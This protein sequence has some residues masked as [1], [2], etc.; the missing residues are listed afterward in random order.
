MVPQSGQ[1]SGI[2]LPYEQAA[3]RGEEMPKGLDYPD[4]ILFIMLRDLY[5]RF[6]NGKIEKESARKEKMQYL[7]EYRGYK[8]NWEMGQHWAQVLIK[9]DLARSEYKKNP[10]IENADRLVAVL[11]G[12]D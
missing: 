7:E 3:I 6:R 2:V 9:T 11:D 5:E 8:Q 1:S 10:T 4:Q 12:M